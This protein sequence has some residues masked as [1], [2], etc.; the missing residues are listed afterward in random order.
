MQHLRL[1]PPTPKAEAAAP[2]TAIPI[3]ISMNY[4]VPAFPPNSFFHL[5]TFLGNALNHE[6]GP[7]ATVFTNEYIH[8]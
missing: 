5:K 4:T 3:S 6:E 7:A 1:L 8:L 2:K